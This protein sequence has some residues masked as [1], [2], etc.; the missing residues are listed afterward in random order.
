MGRSLF[1]L[2]SAQRGGGFFGLMHLDGSEIIA[3]CPQVT[4]LSF[5]FFFFFG[6]FMT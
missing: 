1:F 5:N 6:C 4:F 2:V 3:M